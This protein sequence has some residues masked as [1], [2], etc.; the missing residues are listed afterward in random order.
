MSGAHRAVAVTGAGTGI[1]RACAIAFAR[2]GSQVA[3]VGPRRADLDAV[4]EEVTDAGGTPLVL[5][6]DL[7][8]PEAV[9]AAFASIDAVF[10]GLDVL[11]A[12]AARFDHR[13][14]V[15]EM[16][17]ADVN[18]ILAVNVLGTYRCVRAAARLMTRDRRPGRMVLISAVQS[19]AP[20]P[21]W[22]AYAASKGAIDALTRSLAVELTP[23]GIVVNAVAPGAVQTHPRAPTSS[24]PTLLGR[25]GQPDEVAAL[26][27]FLASDRCSFV[28][29]QTILCDGGRLLVPRDD[30]QDSAASSAV[31]GR[32]ST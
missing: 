15:L 5:V 13:A 25:M 4:A 31:S 32:S 28:V 6:A 16:S 27:E 29:G 17:D 24:D 7:S 30:P 19:V 10:S 26:I 20:L 18:D 12:N 11:V 22:S 9:E 8:Q 1:G 3:L 21:G 2:S 23:M 14:P